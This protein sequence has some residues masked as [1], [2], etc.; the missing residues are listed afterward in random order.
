MKVD[1]PRPIDTLRT[2]RVR[3][4]GAAAGGFAPEMAQQPRTAAPASGAAAISS[5]DALIALQEVPEAITGRAKAARRGRDMLDALDEVRDGL[6]TGAISRA[7]LQRL[8]T[9]VSVDRED[10]VDPNLASVLDE[11]ELR[12]KVELAKLNLAVAN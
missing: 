8:L 2:T 4:P 10:F 9:L 3:A 12:A 11:I 7:T 5:V 1:A 6:L